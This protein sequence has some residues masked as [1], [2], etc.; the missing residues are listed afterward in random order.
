MKR[1]LAGLSVVVLLGGLTSCA[2]DDQA[3][4]NSK[5]IDQDKITV[6]TD[7]PAVPVPSDNP[8]TQA[9]AD[10]GRHLFYDTRLSTNGQL[11]CASCHQ[12][13]NGFSDV[14]KDVS[15][16]VNQARGTRNASSLSNIAYQQNFFWDGRRHS[17]EQQAFDPVLNPIELG[18]STQAEVAKILTKLNQEPKY[19]TLFTNAFG[20]DRIDVDRISKAIASFER[21]MIS[22]NSEYDK[23]RRK[24]PTAQ[25]GEAEK[26]G[27]TLF[28]DSNTNCSRCHEGV[29]FT[30]D[31]FHSTGIERVY[32]DGGLEMITNRPED[33]GKFK[34]P[35]LRNVA[36]TAPYDHNGMFKD[37]KEII[38]HYNEGGM[39]NF[40]QDS[41]IHQ[42]NLSDAQVNDIV[43]FLNSLTDR[44]FINNKAFK[45]P[46]KE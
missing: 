29:N 13:A 9:K 22:G 46:W 21:T 3:P 11:S 30:D 38:K 2:E 34:T 32:G 31:K 19:K 45:N 1:L 28:L 33:N 36:L 40:T 39:K 14:G 10:L 20:D 7:F 26:R 6:P 23:W 37:L 35:S 18:A 27:L 24:D 17:L 15:I 42:L 5:S 16:G 44:D 8:F 25:F 41:L 4:V 12:V 43:A